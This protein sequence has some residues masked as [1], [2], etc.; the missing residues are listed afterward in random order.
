MKLS[1]KTK[2]RLVIIMI[3]LVFICFLSGIFFYLLAD[4][5]LSEEE[6]EY[7][8]RQKCIEN[9]TDEE[10]ANTFFR[11]GEGVNATI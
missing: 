9:M 8:E 11:L 7:Y 3:L 4:T 5:Q 1:N 6:K 2:D 10:Y